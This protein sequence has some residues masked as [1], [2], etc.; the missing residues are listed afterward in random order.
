MAYKPTAPPAT[1]GLHNST[2]DT[3]TAPSL[4]K[5]VTTVTT[6]TRLLGMSLEGFA[7]QDYGIQVRVPWLDD[8]LWFVPT[9]AHSKVLIHEGTPRGRIWTAGELRDLISLPGID[10]ND[11]ESIGRLRAAFDA[12]IVA[13]ERDESAAP[14]RPT[15]ATTPPACPNCHERRFWR[16]TQGVTVCGTCHP[17]ASPELVAEWIEGDE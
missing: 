9:P 3:S 4:P 6:V 2:P 7:K 14:S 10:R 11:I 13:V 15:E 16:S 1:A 8:T 12:E 17:P 5:A